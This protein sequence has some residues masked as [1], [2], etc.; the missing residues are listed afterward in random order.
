MCVKAQSDWPD[1]EFVTENNHDMMIAMKKLHMSCTNKKVE[2]LTAHIYFGNW[3]VR[4]L[5]R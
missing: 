3:V 4:V 2:L 5:I 1:V